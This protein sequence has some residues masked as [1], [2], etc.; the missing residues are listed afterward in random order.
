[1]TDWLIDWLI[2]LKTGLNKFPLFKTKGVKG[3]TYASMIWIKIWRKIFVLYCSFKIW[4]WCRK[5]L[6]SKMPRTSLAIPEVSFDVILHCKQTKQVLINVAIMRYA[7][8]MSTNVES[9]LFRSYRESRLYARAYSK[10]GGYCC[11]QN[12]SYMH[13]GLHYTSTHCKVILKQL[14]LPKFRRSSLRDG[15]GQHLGWVGLC[16]NFSFCNSLSNLGLVG[17]S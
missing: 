1:M 15:L 16:R 9:R 3:Y 4:F 14:G 17:S 2:E 12:R 13:I 11:S 10:A 7:A 6:R 8:C 5:I